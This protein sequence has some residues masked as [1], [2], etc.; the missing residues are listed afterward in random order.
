[1][2]ILAQKRAGTISLTESAVEVLENLKTDV[3]SNKVDHFKGA[4]GMVQA[5]LDGSIDVLRRSDAFLQHVERFVADEGVDA[6]GDE[7]RGFVD[8]Y[9]FL[10]HAGGDGYAGRDG[11]IGRVR[12]TDD[13]DQLHFGDGIEEVHADATVALEDDVAEV[14]DGE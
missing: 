4:H 3:Q 7:A 1:M 14:A 6:G 8:D 12:G 11:F 2:N 13:F 10:A 5:E 9:G